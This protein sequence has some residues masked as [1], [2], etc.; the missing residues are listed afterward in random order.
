MRRAEPLVID[1]FVTTLAG[2]RLHEELAGNFLTA[3]DLR[4]TWEKRAFGTVALAVHDGR[5]HLGIFNASTILP[6]GIS[7]VPSSR[8]EAGK[9]EQADCY[10]RDRW[11]ERRTLSH[12]VSEKNGCACEREDDV[13]VEPIP[14]RAGRADLDEHES[15]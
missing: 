6:A 14:I 12:A 10:A 4:R 7:Q 1:V 5:R 8:A 9:D 13:C 11:P 3:V 2:V 15:D